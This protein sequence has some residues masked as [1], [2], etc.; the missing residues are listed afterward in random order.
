MFLSNIST[1]P[2]HVKLIT[3]LTLA[4]GERNDLGSHSEILERNH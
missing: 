3:L 1:R 4:K 2:L